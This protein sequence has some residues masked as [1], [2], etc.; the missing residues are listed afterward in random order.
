MVVANFHFFVPYVGLL[1]FRVRNDEDGI[2]VKDSSESWATK[3]PN[4]TVS[5]YWYDRSYAGGLI[6]RFILVSVAGGQS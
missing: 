6:G 1:R 3:H 2:H 5:T 4:P